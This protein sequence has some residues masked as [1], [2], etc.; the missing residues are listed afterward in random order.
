MTSALPGRIHRYLHER[1]PHSKLDLDER[2]LL[3]TANGLREQ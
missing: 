2:Q 3:E 1:L